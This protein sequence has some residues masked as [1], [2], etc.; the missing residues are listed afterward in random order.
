MPATR[1]SAA[2]KVR[3]SARCFASTPR[4][5]RREPVN[6]A[7]AEYSRLL[8]T[9]RPSI[10]PLLFKAVKRRIEGGHVKRDHAF[11]ALGDQ[12]GDLVAVG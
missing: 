10:S 11:A 5:T 6:N 3:Q 8:P 4:P 2:E 7:G 12:L 9:H 1:S